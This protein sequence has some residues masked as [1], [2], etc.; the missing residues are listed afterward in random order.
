MYQYFVKSCTSY[1]FR[2]TRTRCILFLIFFDCC[3]D[4]YLNSYVKQFLTLIN[5]LLLTRRIKVSTL[6]RFFIFTTLL[7]FSNSLKDVIGFTT[8]LPPTVRDVSTGLLHTRSEQHASIFCREHPS[9]TLIN[10][11]HLKCNHICLKI[12]NLVHQTS[13]IYHKSAVL[14]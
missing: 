4:F 5:N 9:G 8:G 2:A 3:M 11:L 14:F 10:D 6:D 7:P 1:K 13:H 12:A